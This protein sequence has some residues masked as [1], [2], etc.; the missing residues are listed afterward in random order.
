MILL[1]MTDTL[2][3]LKGYDHT[4]AVSICYFRVFH[5]IRRTLSTAALSGG[6]LRGQKNDPGQTVTVVPGFAFLVP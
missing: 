6:V 1:S 2:N 3:R 4:L 5:L